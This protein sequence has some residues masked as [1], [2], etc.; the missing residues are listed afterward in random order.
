MAP[1]TQRLLQADLDRIVGSSDPS[2]W[3][4]RDTLGKLYNSLVGAV[5]LEELRL[6]PPV[7]DVPKV[8]TGEKSA[9]G[10]GE[11]IHRVMI[12]EGGE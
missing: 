6:I 9:E 2:T 12:S 5:M 10:K 1:T 8:P 4:Y 7:I 11:G 3:T